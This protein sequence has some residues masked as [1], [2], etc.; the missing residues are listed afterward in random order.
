MPKT[1][2]NKKKMNLRSNWIFV[3]E[4]DCKRERERERETGMNLRFERYTISNFFRRARAEFAEKV[5]QCRF[6]DNGR[7]P[8]GFLNTLSSSR[9]R[10]S[11]KGEV[12]PALL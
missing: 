5:L 3:W 8:A 2:N 10:Q 9:M 7:P 1:N 4:K 6:T 12:G 11:W